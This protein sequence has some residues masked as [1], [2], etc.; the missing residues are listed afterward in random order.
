[1]KVVIPQALRHEMI[2]RTHSSH[3][4]IEALLRKARDVIYWPAMNAE[5]RDFIGEFSTC[6]ELGQKQCKELMMT[7]Q[8]PKRPWSRVGMDLFSCLGKEYLEFNHC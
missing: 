3:L 1:M 4:G 8:I 2:K 7:H 5:V 6:N